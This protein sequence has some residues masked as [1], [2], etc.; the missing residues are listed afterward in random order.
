MKYNLDTMLTDTIC[1]GQLQ[2]T[3]GMLIN[4]GKSEHEA[5]LVGAFIEQ[6]MR[7]MS[8]QGLD[9]DTP[10]KLSSEDKFDGDDTKPF[11]EMTFNIPVFFVVELAHFFNRHIQG[12][13]KKTQNSAKYLLPAWKPFLQK[14]A[15][16]IVRIDDVV[17]HAKTT[18]QP[19]DIPNMKKAFDGFD[20]TERQN[21]NLN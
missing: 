7:Q 5:V 3:C 16:Y 21:Y 20:F 6:V 10:Y 2:A 8:L 13:N 15:D 1:A 19:K 12:T 11:R 18:L 14:A 4:E 17:S 9:S